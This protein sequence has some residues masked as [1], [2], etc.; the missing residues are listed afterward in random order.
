MKYLKL[1]EDFNNQDDILEDIK[2]IM[3]EVSEDAKLISSELDGD[4]LFYSL[5]TECSEEDLRVSKLRLSD[6]NY[7]IVY[8]N[9]NYCWI[10][11]IDILSDEFKDLDEIVFKTGQ[12]KNL[13]MAGNLQKIRKY[14][15]FKYW[16]KTP[17]LSYDILK[18]FL[19]KTDLA[20]G[21]DVFLSSLF[22]DFLGE[23][24]IE[25]ILNE[26]LEKNYYYDVSA[27]G[28]LYDRESEFNFSFEIDE[29]SIN[30]VEKKL[31]VICVVDYDGATI[32]TNGNELE[33][34][35]IYDDHETTTD[36]IQKIDDEL[37]SIMVEF[38]YTDLKVWE[39][40]GLD[41]EVEIANIN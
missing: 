26:I 37:E 29:F 7:K 5:D 16:E 22:I 12:L 28:D 11:N 35:D 27:N 24:R 2:W 14:L 34:L 39:R 31:N 32:T 19:N 6:L 21:D 23:E 38:I 41:V 33:I 4:L 10:V 17:I 18:L 36:D 15:L 40:T 8:F 25:K 1:Y 3:I 20:Y 9:N 30:V 13:K